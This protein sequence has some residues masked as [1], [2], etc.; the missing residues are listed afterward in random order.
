VWVRN[1]IELLFLHCFIENFSIWI[2]LRVLTQPGAN[3]DKNP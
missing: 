1:M 3:I 2:T